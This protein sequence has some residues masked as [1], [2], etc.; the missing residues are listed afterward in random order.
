MKRILT[1]TESVTIHNALKT[2]AQKYREIAVQ[3]KQ[4]PEH[5]DETFERQAVEADRLADEVEGYLI[6]LE[7]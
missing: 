1:E 2:A 7:Q 6:A 5:L 3:C 4:S